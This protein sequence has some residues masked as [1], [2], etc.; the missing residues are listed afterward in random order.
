MLKVF[1]GVA[2]GVFIYD[3]PEVRQVNAYLLHAAGDAIAP[4]EE[5]KTLKIRI[6]KL[7]ESE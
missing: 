6:K 2:I 7:L 3:N 5:D 1:L 4:A